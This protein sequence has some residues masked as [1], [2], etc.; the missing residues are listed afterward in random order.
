MTRLILIR[1]GQTEWNIIGKFQGQSDTELS[2]EGIRQAELLAEHFEEFYANHIDAIYSSDL[3]RARDTAETLG[4]KYSMEVQLD[5]RLREVHFGKWEGESISEIKKSDPKNFSRLFTS[6]DLLKIDGGET[7]EQVQIRAMESIREI[8]DKNSN[9]T[10][11][12]AAH[13]AILRTIIGAMLDVPLRC[14]WK[15]RQD[16]TAV[17]LARVDDGNFM[18]ALI[19]GTA[20]LKSSAFS[21]DTL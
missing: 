19:N 2:S 1:H 8:I 4:R 21:F 5:S 16:N 7:F 15:I 10:V 3:K 9:R 6:P 17:N 12:V 14:I 13:G 20:H 18:L 11:V